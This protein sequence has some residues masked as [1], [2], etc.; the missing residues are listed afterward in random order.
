MAQKKTF[1]IYYYFDN[2]IHC[3]FEV[4]DCSNKESFKRGW[5]TSRPMPN[6]FRSAYDVTEKMAASDGWGLVH[7]TS[8]IALPI[9]QIKMVDE[10][11]QD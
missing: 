10:Y 7:E 2:F 11:I 1:I 5:K 3:I 4:I 8:N 9:P 6:L